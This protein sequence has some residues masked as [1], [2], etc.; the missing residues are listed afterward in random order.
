LRTAH[1]FNAGYI[2]RLLNDSVLITNEDYWGSKNR[3]NNTFKASYQYS[4]EH[5]D[6]IVYPT[7]GHYIGIE[8]SGA[9]ADKLSFFYGQLKVKF[10]YYKELY[11]RWFW[12][13]RIN[14]SASFKNKRA[15]IYDQNVGYEDNIITG[16]DYYVVDGQHYAILNNDIRF[17]LIPKKVV[18]F[19]SLKFLSGFKKIHLSLYAKLSCDIGYVYNNYRHPS[20]TMA[21]SLLLGSCAGIDF[22]TYYDIVLNCS[23]GI[24]KSGDRGWFFGIKAPVF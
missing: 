7:K 15:Y 1:T 23:Y 2:N 11:P 19:Q 6:Y 22:V 9:T 24:N 4:Y 21:N 16:Y 13:S 5:R 18:D 8:A 20:N 10:Q 17:S 14:A 3:N 12:G